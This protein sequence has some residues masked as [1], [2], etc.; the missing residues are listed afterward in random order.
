M[1]HCVLIIRH[2][3]SINRHFNDDDDDNHFESRICPSEREIRQVRNTRKKTE[4]DRER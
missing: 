3:S 4:I 1:L 2:V